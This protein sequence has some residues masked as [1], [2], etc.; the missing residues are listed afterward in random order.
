MSESDPGR[1]EEEVRC[2]VSLLPER[3]Q[4]IAAELPSPLLHSACVAEELD[5]VRALVEAGLPVDLYPETEDEDDVPPLT[6]VARY[7]DTSSQGGLEVAKFLIESSGD[8]NE[9]SP[10]YAALESKDVSMIR[11]LLAAGADRDIALERASLDETVLLNSLLEPYWRA[12]LEIPCSYFIAFNEDQEIL[13]VGLSGPDAQRNAAPLVQ[14]QEL[15]TMQA[16]ERLIARYLT[17]VTLS[18][19]G[20]E[21]AD[22]EDDQDEEE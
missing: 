2:V 16:S 6:W 8:V 13:G 9:G 14:E 22:V 11:L 4:Q 17:G 21:I 15:E 3:L 20:D 19:E 1:V 7:R 12:P 10:L 5:L 18:W